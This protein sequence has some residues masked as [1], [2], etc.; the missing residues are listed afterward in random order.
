MSIYAPDVIGTAVLNNIKKALTADTTLACVN[1]AHTTMKKACDK[2]LPGY[3]L[4]S[5]GSTTVFGLYEAKSD[6]DFVLLNNDDIKR[7]KGQDPNTQTAKQLQAHRLGALAKI[8][9]QQNPSWKIEEVKRARVP[10]LKVK[11]PYAAFDVTANR[12]NGVRNSYLLRGYF[13]QRPDAR[14]LAIAL[15]QWSKKVGINGLPAGF[16]TS[17]SF[18]ILVA[19]YLLRRKMVEFVPVEITDVSR[20]PLVAG[21]IPIEQPKAPADFG[22]LIDDFFN[23]YNAEFQYD[24]EVISL[25]RPGITLRTDLNWTLEQEDFLKMRSAEGEK[26]AY[27]LCIEDPYE[28][29]LNLGRNVTSFKMDLFKQSM[30]R[31]QMTAMEFLPLPEEKKV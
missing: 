14:W 2:A 15:K 19:Y 9:R 20:V 11:S 23:F 24:K 6:F 25:S 7:G 21:G 22:Y 16:L 8:I 13:Q 27:R 10:V 29:N 12:R 26:I 1:A 31:A 17:Y 30:I 4:Y 5:F 3:H 28:E 18:N